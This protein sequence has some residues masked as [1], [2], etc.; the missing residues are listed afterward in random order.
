LYTM[1]F[2]EQHLRYALSCAISFAFELSSRYL[3]CH[4]GSYPHF[5]FY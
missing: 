1:D 2:Y 3:A 4:G 5:T